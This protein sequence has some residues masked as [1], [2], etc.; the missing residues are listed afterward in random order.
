VGFVFL[1]LSLIFVFDRG[2]DELLGIHR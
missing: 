2:T 1:L